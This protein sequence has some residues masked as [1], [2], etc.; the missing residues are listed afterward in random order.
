LFDNSILVTLLD[1]E[2]GFTSVLQ[3]LITIDNAS[4]VSIEKYLIFCVF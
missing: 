2:I 1:V 3:L 4:S